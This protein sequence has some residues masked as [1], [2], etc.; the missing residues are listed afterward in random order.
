MDAFIEYLKNTKNKAENTLVAYRR[1]L[2]AFEV[3][4]EGRGGKSLNDCKESDAAAYI[5]ELNNESKSK[6]TINRKISSLRAFYDYKIDEGERETN[7][8]QKI[9]SAK[10]DKRQIEFLT[11]EEVNQMLSLP[12]DSAKGIRDKALLEFM[13]GTGARVT[14]LVRL[15]FSDMNLLMNFV[16]LKDNDGE[17]RIV[18]IGS[19]AHAA[20]KKYMDEAYEEIK[21]EPREE[22]DYIFINFRGQALTRQ[23]IW[24][25]LKEYGK[26]MDIEERM[27]PQILRNSFAVHIL[28]N[29]GD[30]KTLQELMGF[31]DMSVGIA[32]LA[33]LNVR[34]RDVYQRTHPRA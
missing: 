6:A 13:Y 10:N 31:E 22:D 5:L 26:E 24:K 27:T 15:R 25:I 33:V 7:P 4:L 16:T 20:M 29:G 1:D 19:Y 28:Q 11:V 23:G 3:F 21:G 9:K 2:K 34:I 14:E 12:D 30:L 8:F 18:P 17:S 32:Y